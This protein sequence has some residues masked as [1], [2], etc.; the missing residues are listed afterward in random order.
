MVMGAGVAN[1]AFTGPITIPIMKK[2]G[3]SP[4]QAGAIEAAA[5]AGGQVT[6]PVMAAVAFLMAGILGITYGR[7][8]LYAAIPAVIYFLSIGWAVHLLALRQ[9]IGTSAGQKVD[10][11]MVWRRF[12]VFAIPLG[13]VI[14]LLA[15]D[16]SPTLAAFCAIISI[17]VLS[18]IRKETR[19]TWG[20]LVA[21]FRTGCVTA[22]GLS[23]AIA[24]IGIVS[25]MVALTGLG[26]QVAFSV[27]QWSLGIPFI[28]VFVCMVVTIFLGCGIP[29]V[30]AYALVAII[31]APVLIRMGLGDV[32]THLFIIYYAAFSTLSPP[33]ASA[34]LMGSSISGG[35]YFK[36]AVESMKVAAVAFII[37]WLFMWN[38]NI[39]AVFTGLWSGIGSLLSTV[40]L[41]FALQAGLFGQLLVRLN[42]MERVVFVFVSA[43]LAAYVVTQNA[44]SFVIGLA[45][46]IAMLLGQISKAR[47]RQAQE[48]IEQIV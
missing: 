7:V 43:I 39:I 16:Y 5:S 6:P 41:I 33:V 4:D 32:E 34:A 23:L 27:E 25:S 44:I 37:P 1:V 40:V 20:R 28:A 9:G 15:M 14:V 47:S 19:L 38:T 18:C 17:L 21:G 11:G 29:V 30:A 48:L 3:Y 26:V 22:S 8:I 24:T 36:T 35:S 46:F 31:V 2:A 10:Y 13:V 45:L 42:W 12:P